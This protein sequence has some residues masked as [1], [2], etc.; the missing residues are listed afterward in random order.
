MEKNINLTAVFHRVKEGYIAWIEEI[1]GVNTQGETIEEA[2][3]NLWDALRMVLQANK[4]LT[5]KSEPR[6]NITRKPFH[7]LNA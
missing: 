3:S 4:K 7:V 1:P 5:R 2:T 6:T